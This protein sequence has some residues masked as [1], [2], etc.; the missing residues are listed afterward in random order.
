MNSNTILM[1]CI[2]SLFISLRT[3]QL[4]IEREISFVGE[5]GGISVCLYYY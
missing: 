2:Y 3:T 1:L 5:N 4:E